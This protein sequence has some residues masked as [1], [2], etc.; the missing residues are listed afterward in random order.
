M[1]I[2]NRRDLP[3]SHI[4]GP[5]RLFGREFIPAFYRFQPFRHLLSPSIMDYAFFRAI[6]V[7]Y[8][9]Y[10]G[11]D[12]EMQRLSNEKSCTHGAAS[13]RRCDPAALSGRRGYP[14]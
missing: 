14:T 12:I 7:Q 9:K 8:V 10:V 1:A 4:S 3:A 13:C 11:A 2:Q 6:R 5:P